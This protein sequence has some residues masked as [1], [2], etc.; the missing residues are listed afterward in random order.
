M[1]LL[2]FVLE[3]ASLHATTPNGLEVVIIDGLLLFRLDAVRL[4]LDLL[5]VVPV[6]ETPLD[7]GTGGIL[8]VLLH[9]VECVL[10]HVGDTKIVV[11]EESTIRGVGR[12]GVS[13]DHFHQSRLSRSVG[14]D[15]AD[16]RTQRHLQ[17]NVRQCIFL[18]TGIAVVDAFH[19]QESLGGGTNTLE[20]TRVWED[21]LEIGCGE[22]EVVFGLGL[23][24]DEGGHFSS[25]VDEFAVRSPLRTMFIVDDITAN[26]LQKWRIV[27]HNQHSRVLQPLQIIL[28]PPY[29]LVIQ[30]IRRF[31]H[32]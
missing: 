8:N 29:R 20:A 4:A 21:E 25:V 17:V 32:Q 5:L 24:L 16:A 28:Q 3:H 9:V 1:F 15:E 14:A 22:F 23:F 10:G 7:V 27:T 18:G 26:I 11:N 12:L 19:F 30:V 2:D 31:V 6:L 13:H